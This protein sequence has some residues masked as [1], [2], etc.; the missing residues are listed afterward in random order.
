M[1]PV[2]ATEYRRL[3]DGILVCAAALVT[4]AKRIEATPSEPNIATLVGAIACTQ[5]HANDDPEFLS[6]LRIRAYALYSIRE[7]WL[8]AILE[9]LR[10]HLWVAHRGTN[11][12][13][14]TS[15]YSNMPAFKLQIIRTGDDTC[16]VLAESNGRSANSADKRIPAGL[17]GE[18]LASLKAELERSYTIRGEQIFD[19]EL[20]ETPAEDVAPVAFVG[21]MPGDL[22]RLRDVRGNPKIADRRTDLKITEEIGSQLFKFLFDDRVE[23]LFRDSDCAARRGGEPLPVRLCVEHPAL[24]GIPWEVMFDC[25]TKSYLSMSQQN[26]LSRFVPGPDLQLNKRKLPLEIAGMIAMPQNLAHTR[27]AELDA[28]GEV[29]RIQ[30]ILKTGLKD[31][32][33]IRWTT[34]GR[35]FDLE[36]LLLQ[37]SAWSAFHFIG[38][39]GLQEDGADAD[40]LYADALKNILTLPGGAGPQLVVLNSC[41]GGYDSPCHELFSSAAADLVLGGVPIVVAMQYRIRDDVAIEFSRLFYRYLA[42]GVTIERAMALTRN[43]LRQKT[44]QWIAPVVDLR[45]V[46]GAKV[47]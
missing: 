18:A 40:V 1:T 21:K 47:F 3:S 35:Q 25:Q 34:T 37:Q 42:M 31:K 45:T 39:G 14:C 23:D 24:A 43:V 9:H 12:V 4:A 22:G 6:G 29:E 28:Q 16:R 33:N 30:E 17:F 7:I 2:V 36:T 20:D 41:E 5:D 32:A 38:H 10:S 19:I 11:F 15:R 8:Y 13:G 44:A 46:D 27:L 26:C